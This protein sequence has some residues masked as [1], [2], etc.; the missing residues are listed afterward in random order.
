MAGCSGAFSVPDSSAGASP[1]VVT[2]PP[3]K[4][5]VYGG[6]APIQG[7]HVYLA[8]PGISGYGSAAQSILGTGTT[9]TPGGYP[10]S[11]NS[12]GDPNVPASARYV[13]TDASGAFNLTGAYTCTAGQPVF[14]Y[15]YGGTIGPV[16]ASNVSYTISQ[17]VV[18]NATNGAGGTA[19]YTVTVNSTTPLPVGQAVTIGG[20]PNNNNGFSGYEWSI[21]N[22]SQTVIA[23][24]APGLN[25]FSFTATDRYGLANI[26]NGTY[27]NNNN[28]DQIG[29]GGTA[30]ASIAATGA[31]TN[32]SIVQLATLGNCPSGPVNNFG[33]GSSDDIS[34][35]Y[36]NEVSTVA[37]AYTFQPFTL[38]TNNNAWDIGIPNP[39]TDPLALTGIYN[40][41]ATAA[42]LYDI[43]GTQG[44]TIPSLASGEGH[45]ANR[46]TAGAGGPDAGNGIVP[47][48]T[49]DTLANILAAC[50]DS[51]PSSST[52]VTVQCNDLFS[53]ATADGTTTGTKPTDSGTA[54]IDIARFPAG[55][56]SSTS[57]D[58][59]YTSDLWALQASGS[60]PYVPDLTT[61]PHDWTIAINYPSNA[62]TGYSTAV[63][64]T[65]GGPESIAVDGLGQI[66]ATAQ[67]GYNINRFTPL[68]AI[69][70][71][72]TN[73]AYI[74]G[75]VSI[76]PNNNAWMGNA[77]I[78][79]EN[80]TN[81]GQGN[82]FANGVLG[83]PIDNIQSNA[84]AA[85][86]PN[87]SPFTAFEE[88][89]ITLPAGDSSG[90]IYA[91]AATA[92]TGTGGANG[93]P[94]Y[95]MFELDS[96]GNIIS[97]PEPACNN[98]AGGTPNYF[99]ISSATAATSS[100]NV[101]SYPAHGAIT[102]FTPGTTTLS[103]TP[104]FWL[105]TEQQSTT[106]ANRQIALVSSTGAKRFSFA[107]N[108]NQP[109]FP[110]VDNTG[111]AWIPI[112]GGE[113]YKVTPTLTTPFYTEMTLTGGGIGA[114]LSQ[115]FGAA[116][117]GNGNVWITDRTNN[118]LIELN[119]TGTGGTAPSGSVATP[120][121]R[122][123]RDLTDHQLHPLHP[124][125]RNHQHSYFES[126]LEHCHR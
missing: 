31:V 14:I 125:L 52:A 37:T 70:I 69:N 88:A 110:A 99:C 76:D 57:V 53:I 32:K 54:A 107:T 30:T 48:A 56:S 44:S 92:A 24:P 84:G 89:Y 3:I 86:T 105:T 81:P 20:L 17:I 82:L 91:F 46:L 23:S 83:T 29:T 15:A 28:F 98:G 1:S 96:N 121:D 51:V 80:N 47:Q 119:G 115:P 33:N 126:T 108:E 100:I 41:A 116:V 22:R 65:M 27:V 60:V 61:S 21:L 45:L 64:A 104:Y 42:Q 12:T 71:N 73:S 66:W 97:T 87:Q 90:N 112:N 101:G 34:Y 85:P 79:P 38:L 10:L 72:A 49:I 19:T 67:S 39:S 113:V 50:V 2:G 117:D 59:T 11:D 63:N 36:L 25:T 78:G 120:R 7:A 9:T 55:N 58:A 94:Y 95:E 6:H 111:T 109:E 124:I 75:Y 35:I 4:G 16:A 77:Q 40:A 18:S 74:W 103:T 26:Q 13:T 93:Y 114:A 43:E 118:T 102:Y 62:I 122:Q 5:T 106:N 8:Q 68:G 123:Q